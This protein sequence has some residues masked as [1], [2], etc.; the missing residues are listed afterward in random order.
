MLS[1]SEIING[2][3][4]FYSSENIW[5]EG[6]IRFTDGIRWLAENAGAF[7]LIDLVKSYQ[8]QINAGRINSKSIHDL[9]DFQLWTLKVKDNTAIITCRADSGCEA[10]ITQEIEY[11]DFPLEEFEFYVENGTMLLKSER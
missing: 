1:K 5:R 10:A 6:P 3:S 11:T 2:L 8:P 4:G 9:K 7:W